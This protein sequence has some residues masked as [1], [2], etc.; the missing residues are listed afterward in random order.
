MLPNKEVFKFFLILSLFGGV[1]CIHMKRMFAFLYYTALSILFIAIVSC[2][3][4]VFWDCEIG[5]VNIFSVHIDFNGTS[6]FHKIFKF[7]IQF[8]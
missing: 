3:S 1:F 7:Y 8:C 5:T 4:N 2:L 6:I